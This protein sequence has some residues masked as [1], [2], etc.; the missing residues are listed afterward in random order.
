MQLHSKMSVIMVRIHTQPI[1][2]MTTNINDY[3]I[4]PSLMRQK[5]T[6]SEQLQATWRSSC[7][8]V[9]A[10]MI[11]GATMHLHRVAMGNQKV[12]WSYT[13]SNFKFW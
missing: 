7:R 9:W 10:S 6:G 2:T 3:F 13:F 4:T 11:S 5:I 1:Y 12:F 8:S